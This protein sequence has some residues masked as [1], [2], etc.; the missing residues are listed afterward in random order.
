[1]TKYKYKYKYREKDEMRKNLINLY[2]KKDN[3]LIYVGIATAGV[4][5]ILLYFWKKKKTS[6]ESESGASNK[7]E[8]GASGAVDKYGNMMTV[9]FVWGVLQGYESYCNEKGWK[10]NFKTTQE[11]AKNIYL[12]YLIETG[13]GKY[14]HDCNTHN[15]TAGSWKTDP[16]KASPYIS[17]WFGHQ[18]IGT[19]IRSDRGEK[20][21]QQEF[22]MYDCLACSIMDYLDLINRSKRYAGI[23]ILYNQKDPIFIKE[24]GRAGYFSADANK[25]Y[26]TAKKLK[27]SL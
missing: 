12:H 2:S 20:N 16:K 8:S 5:L 9:D 27:E 15:L 6:G 17:E 21:D 10:Y 3:T 7:T 18:Y 4:L 24:L 11:T 22:R 13:N 23:P 25:I 19:R 14:L 1:M 26:Q